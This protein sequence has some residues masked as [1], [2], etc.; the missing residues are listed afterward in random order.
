MNGDKDL[1]CQPRAYLYNNSPCSCRSALN[2]PYSLRYWTLMLSSRISSPVL[3]GRRFPEGQQGWCSE[4][5]CFLRLLRFLRSI[6]DRPIGCGQEVRSGGTLWYY[7]SLVGAFNI[8]GYSATSERSDRSKA[9][10]EE[11]DR[12]VTEIEGLA[13]VK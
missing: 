8:A 7:R 10:V 3:R 4:R 5:Y 11:L 2:S 1:G 12:V 13:S 9:V 6:S